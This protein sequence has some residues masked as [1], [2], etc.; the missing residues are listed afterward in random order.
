VLTECRDY[1]TAP[2]SVL[3]NGL[4]KLWFRKLLKFTARRLILLGEAS[5]QASS[6][7]RCDHSSISYGVVF[8]FGIGTFSELTAVSTERR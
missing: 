3:D 6:L 1:A 4:S 8:T 2:T 7:I 5:R